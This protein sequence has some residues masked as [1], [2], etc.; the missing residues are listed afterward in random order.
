MF[1]P[2]HSRTVELLREWNYRQ[3]LRSENRDEKFLAPARNILEGNIRHKWIDQYNT[4][5]LVRKRLIK[6]VRAHLF[7]KWIKHNFPEIPIILLLR[8]PC[9]V[10]GSKIEKGWDTH[11]AD[12]LMQEE[13][14][15]DFLNPF[16]DR[17]VATRDI[18][19]KHILM[20]CIENY[21]PLR[22]FSTGEILVTFYENL[23][24]NPRKEIEDILSFV[25][26][27]FSPRVF[28][29][30]AKPSAQ[31]RNESAVVLGTSLINSWRNQI[32]D[33][34]VERAVDILRGFGLQ[35]IYGEDDLPLLTGK[36]ALKVFAAK[37][38]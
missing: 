1:E 24:I 9:A 22:Q 19:E 10:A 33:S 23:C 5:F 37:N 2:F 18:F 25:G 13:L 15:T 35:A 11:L 27:E 12:F 28:H 16:K 36:D 26:M 3:Y 34:Q 32:S 30:H 4:K 29:L 38:L 17:I 14:M 21:V 20:W 6:D 31:S 8:H 7:L